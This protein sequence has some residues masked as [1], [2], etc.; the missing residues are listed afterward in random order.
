[1]SIN[2]YK[3]KFYYFLNDISYDFIDDENSLKLKINVDNNYKNIYV[4]NKI[5]KGDIVLIEDNDKIGC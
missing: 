5:Q 1:M 3:L 4:C 2:N